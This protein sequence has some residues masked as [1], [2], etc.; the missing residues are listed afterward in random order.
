MPAALRTTTP[1]TAPRSSVTRRVAFGLEPHG[2][3]GLR[4]RRVRHVDEPGAA[5]HRFEHEPAPEPELVADLVRLAAEH[6]D[7][8]D[9]AIAH[10]PHGRLRLAD[11]QH[12]EVRVRLVLG[13][14]HQVV[15]EVV[16][17]VRIDF[18]DGLLLVGEVAHDLAELLERLEGEAEAARG[19]EAVAAAPRLGRLLEDE[20]ARAVLLRGQRRAHR[21]VA[22]AHHDHVVLI[23]HR[24]SSRAI[25]RRAPWRRPRAF[26]PLSA[27]R[28]RAGDPPEDGP[29]HEPAAARVVDM[30]E[31]AHHLAARVE[32][33][34]RLPA[35][36]EDL[37]LRVHAY[38]AERERDAAGDG[39]GDERRRVE[40]LRPV[41]LG[42]REAASSRAR[43]SPWRR[44]RPASTAAL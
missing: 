24:H 18:H 39:I 14:A 19:E 22:A 43:P 29:G 41:R 27:G 34:N 16:L 10:P 31:P 44:R 17:G 25:G 26:Q 23:A 40:R 37:R 5:A 32:P 12:R 38:A 3:A 33:G 21:G 36:A 13:D 30:E 6:R 9:A 4:G 42:Q 1:V 28:V 35:R 7:P 20:D 8:A 11:D 15:V 2:D